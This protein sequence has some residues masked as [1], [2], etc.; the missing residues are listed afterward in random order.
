[1]V[2]NFLILSSEGVKFDF[3]N[4][5][6]SEEIEKK[7]SRFDIVFVQDLSISCDKVVFRDEEID[8]YK[9]DYIISVGTPDANLYIIDLAT[10]K[11]PKIKAW[12]NV[13]NHGMVDKF[14]EGTTL[15]A[16]GI[17]IP[18]TT[19]LAFLEDDYINKEAEIVGGFPCVAKKVTGAS[20]DYVELVNSS[21]E[22][23]KFI[24]KLSVPSIIGKRNIIL[25]E[26]IEE[27]KGTDFRV[28][29]VGDKVLGA[30]KRTAKD[31]GFKANVS[32]GGDA[33]KAE[34]SKEMKEYAQ[35][36]M[37]ASGL[38]FAG[39]DFIKSNRGYLV[40]EINISANFQGFET[41][42]GVNVAGEIIE[43][44]LAYE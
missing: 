6:L 12:P 25:Q 9:Y 35:K 8:F 22:I 43:K 1:M 29:C 15:E 4:K 44:F 28:Y 40:L 3:R 30:I 17:P 41:A 26:Y 31:G 24:E 13:Q 18:K 38:M 2:K 21:D 32:L 37:Q 27:S 42:T 33:E 34:I 5:R 11:N 20:G 7:G 39:I 14:T 23:K 36:I 19:L 16:I 10:K